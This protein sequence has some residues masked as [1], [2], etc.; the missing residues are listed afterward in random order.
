LAEKAKAPKKSTW[1]WAIPLVLVLAAMIAY[2][3]SFSG[4]FFFDDLSSIEG[5]P[6]I[7]HLWPLTEALSAPL[8]TTTTGRPIVSLS[9][10]LNYALDGLNV[11]GYH[12]FNLA[13]HVLAA[14]TLFGL[15]RRTLLRYPAVV[16]SNNAAWLAGSVALIWELHPLA[17][18]AVTYVI[19]RTELLASLFLL[20]TLYCVN[21]GSSS[22]H[23]WRWYA[24]AL[25]ACGLG[26]GSK[27]IMAG[28]P[29][30]ALLYDR[31]FLSESWGAVWRKR[32]YVHAGLC[33]A[34]IVLGVS[35]ASGGAHATTIG[36]GFQSVGPLDYLKTQCGAI[37]YY[38]RLAFWP[39]PLSIDYGDWP[40]PGTSVF[41]TPAVYV[42]VG[43]GGL[44]LWMLRRNSWVGFT[45]AFFFI[46]L[47]PSSS[48]VPIVTELVAERRM[49]LPLAA[50]VSLVVIGTYTQLKSGQWLIVAALG[51]AVAFAAL[52]YRRNED[53]RVEL[54]MWQDA[55]EKRPGNPRALTNLGKQFIGAGRI[56][57]GLVH[58][59]KAIALAP[60]Y[61]DALS[62]MGATLDRTGRSAEAIP[63]LEKALGADPEHIDAR[64]NLA[65]ASH[66][67]GNLDA[68]ESGYRE[69]LRR[70][71]QYLSAYNNLAVLLL[72]RGRTDDAIAQLRE[73]LRIDPA[74]ADALKNLSAIE[75]S[76]T[77]P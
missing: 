21:R 77:N 67:L 44:T 20:L 5:N 34:W 30:I 72:A 3:N 14:L 76:R 69:V 42:L 51:V 22:A 70:S 19:Q 74:F 8:R 59:N 6:H 18:E 2:S 4:P 64:Y 53:Y 36:F 1:V 24:A 41:A 26:M 11:R 54:R 13:I 49:Y 58:L 10:A 23:P 28:A 7:R 56:D 63:F 55:V 50:V 9:L 39:A 52:T 66:R 12:A 35:L 27:E 68:A 65:L 17:T 45:G 29:I 15:L 40:V 75:R 32:G 31:V 48:F 43:L 46:V 73:A 62:N 71:P 38:L 47:A 33:A 37:L 57:E 60:T 16:G 61:P 25:A